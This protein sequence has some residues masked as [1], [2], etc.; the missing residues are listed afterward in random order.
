MAMSRT[1]FFSLKDLLRSILL[2]VLIGWLLISINDP[3]HKRFDFT[4]SLA[5]PSAMN[6]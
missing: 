6:G 3:T 2:G 5:P 4:L 1:S